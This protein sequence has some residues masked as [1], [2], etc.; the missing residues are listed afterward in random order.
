MI[1]ANPVFTVT[2]A[3]APWCDALILFG[4]LEQQSWTL[5]DQLRDC[6]LEHGFRLE[7]VLP[8]LTSNTAAILQLR[9]KGSLKHGTLQV[10][11]EFLQDSERRIE[12]YGQKN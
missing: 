7:H 8:S 11:E 1:S 3:D 2:D 4:C 5:F 9:S 6:V 12:L 10:S